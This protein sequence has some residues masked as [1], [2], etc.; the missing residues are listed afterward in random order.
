MRILVIEGDA[1]VASFIRKGLQAE[2]YAV[3]VRGRGDEG[4]ATAREADYNLIVLDINLPG[5]NGFTV[6]E[7][8]HR[9][10]PD[11]PV[12]ILSAESEVETRI[13]AL[14]AGADDYMT[15]PFSF[16]ELA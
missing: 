13:K 1:A 5:I 12:I 9:H 2:H 7:N 6:L 10:K 3:D 14:D 16:R 8:L 11:L 15:K 4:L